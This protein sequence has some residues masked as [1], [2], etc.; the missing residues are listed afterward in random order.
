MDVAKYILEIQPNLTK[1]G[2]Q[3]L[4][5]Y[6]QAWN[7]CW[8]GEPLFEEEFYIPP[9]IPNST[10]TPYYRCYEFYELCPGYRELQTSCLTADV[11]PVGD[12]DKLPRRH[13]ENINIVVNDFVFI[14][15]SGNYPVALV[16]NESNNNLLW[17]QC[18]QKKPI[19]GKGWLITKRSLEKYFDFLYEYLNVPEDEWDSEDNE[20][21]KEE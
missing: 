16:K 13:K 19:E 14:D 4:C 3:T 2:L 18:K 15:D 9:K 7:L 6:S 10:M 11:L 1:P 20:E 5:F 21:E 12:S 8:E 17:T